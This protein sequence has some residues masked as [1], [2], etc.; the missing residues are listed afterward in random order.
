MSRTQPNPFRLAT[1]GQI[2]R[3]RPLHFTFNGS[4]YVGYRGDTLASALLA[5]GVRT[6][7]RSFK[8]HRPRGVFSAG[9]EEPCALVEVGEGPARVPNCRAPAVALEEGLVAC[10]QNGW[11]S[12]GFDLGRIVDFTHPLWPAGFYNK[13]FKWP[14]WKAWEGLV[15]RAAGLGR[16]LEAPDPDRYEQVN[17][18]C[19]LLICGGGAT[20]LIAAHVAAGAGLKVILAEQSRV[21][22]GVL[23]SENIELDEQPGPEWARR[24]VAELKNHP[25]VLPGPFAPGTFCWPREPLNRA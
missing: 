13:T 23:I 21:C 9:E 1:G 14:S 12:V 11:P 6:V 4:P 24:M 15:R 7:A 25:N 22:G 2:D 16:P 10:S 17:A 20:G 3:D 18:H 19:D 5:N 8:Y